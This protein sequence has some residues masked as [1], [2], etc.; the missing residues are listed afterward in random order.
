[1]DE[2]KIVDGKTSTAKKSSSNKNKD[3]FVKGATL[4]PAEY[5]EF[6]AKSRLKK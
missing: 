6:V 4:T 3:G 2:A 5:R 1:M